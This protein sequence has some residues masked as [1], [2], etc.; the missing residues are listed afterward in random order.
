MFTP[1]SSVRIGHHSSRVRA[2]L[3]SGIAVLAAAFLLGLASQR[4]TPVAAQLA[5]GGDCCNRLELTVHTNALRPGASIVP[6]AQIAWKFDGGESVPIFFEALYRRDDGGAGADV[7]VIGFVDVFGDVHQL[8]WKIGQ[9]VQ[10]AEDW[11]EPDPSCLNCEGLPVVTH[12]G[13]LSRLENESAL[14]CQTGPL[15]TAPCFADVDHY[16]SICQKLRVDYSGGANAYRFKSFVYWFEGANSSQGIVG[17][18][19][20]LLDQVNLPCA[21]GPDAYRLFSDPTAKK[22]IP[23]SRWSQEPCAS[24]PPMVE[25]CANI[26]FVPLF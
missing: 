14:Q 20:G 17:S 18:V 2:R 11:P 1:S 25:D 4:P 6:P 16:F 12:N 22:V 7:R 13:F 3:C 5:N 23:L 19:D 21:P 15:A 9:G 26:M 24:F 10:H 8:G